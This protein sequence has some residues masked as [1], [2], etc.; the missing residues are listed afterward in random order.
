MRYKIANKQEEFEC[1]KCG[2]PLYIGETAWQDGAN[3]DCFCSALCCE[4]HGQ[5]KQARAAERAI[6]RAERARE[7]S[8]ITGN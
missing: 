7:E 4:R 5:P 3:G 8:D 2:Q 6:E 1:P